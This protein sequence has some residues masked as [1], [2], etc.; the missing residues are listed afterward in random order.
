MT[1]SSEP[2]L[3]TPSRKGRRVFYGSVLTATL[4]CISYSS[5]R[6][7]TAEGDIP[8][9]SGANTGVYNGN[10]STID[11][12]S[13]FVAPKDPDRTF[14]AD[15]QFGYTAASG[16]D[17][18]HTL[19]GQGDFNWYHLPWS[20]NVHL[21][22]YNSGDHTSGTAEHYVGAFRTRYDLDS[23][24]Y[25]FSQ[26]RGV[27]DRFSGYHNQISLAG[28]YGRQI[29][30]SEHNKFSID[31]GPGIRRDDLIGGS[32]QYRALGYLGFDYTHAFTERASFRQ[33]A[34]VEAAGID[35][36][37]RSE[38]S[39]NLGLSKRFSLSLA[40]LVNYTTAPPPNAEYTT[41]TTTI[42]SLDYSL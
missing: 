39:L 3:I 31:M 36:T 20:Y 5:A 32:I 15:L 41:D 4:W 38:T 13:T 37:M 28:G 40:Y 2:L 16:N 10:Y 30:N 11:D 27:A 14:K 34:A 33:Q 19:Y 42:I 6:A 9:S 8:T 22:A 29:V 17:T 18:T 35:L 23:S 12:F 1:P 24:S 26:L 25:L 7:I 21:Y